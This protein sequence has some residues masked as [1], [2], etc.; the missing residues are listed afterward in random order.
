MLLLFLTLSSIVFCS[1]HLHSGHNQ[2]IACSGDACATSFNSTWRSTACR[3]STESTL[4]NHPASMTNHLHNDISPHY[5]APT[6]VGTGTGALISNPSS[7]WLCP[8]ES[9]SRFSNLPDAY[10]RYPITASFRNLSSMIFNGSFTAPGGVPTVS[11]SF[12]NLSSMI[13]NGSFTAPGGVPT[14]SASFRNLSSII[15]NGSLTAPGSVPTV[16][17][18]P[19]HMTIFGRGFL[20]LLSAFVPLSLYLILRL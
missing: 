16:S 14:I 7:S 11:A 18:A 6:A 2:S 1:A 20:R 9:A 8:T 15:F 10:L 17:G 3:R 13:F 12:R 5:P 19:R 4:I